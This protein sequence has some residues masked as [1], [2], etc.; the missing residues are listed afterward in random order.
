MNVI[1][2]LILKIKEAIQMETKHMKR[3][4]IAYVSG[5]KCKLKQQ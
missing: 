4:S 2:K 3:C 5:K 1:N